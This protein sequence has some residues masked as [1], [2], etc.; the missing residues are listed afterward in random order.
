M[1]AYF[2]GV[3]IP[4]LLS[5][6]TLLSK[7]VSATFVLAA[8]LIAEGE[9]PFVHIGAIV[10]GGHHLCGIQAC[11]ITWACPRSHLTAVTSR[12]NMRRSLCT[13]TQSTASRA[14]C[15]FNERPTWPP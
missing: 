6:R 3:H 10:G 14:A 12:G 11:T 2:N 8:G 1:Q 15:A 4:G 13:K 5:L 9:A 7:L